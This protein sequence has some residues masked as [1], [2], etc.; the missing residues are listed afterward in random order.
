MDLPA[1]SATPAQFRGYISD[2]LSELAGLAGQIGDSQLECSMR[3][4]ALEA[5]LA[6]PSTDI[7]PP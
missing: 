3:L 4:L 6:K 2:M 7:P 1:A 5:A